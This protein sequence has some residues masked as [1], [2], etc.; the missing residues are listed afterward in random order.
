MGKRTG[1]TLFFVAGLLS[2]TWGAGVFQSAGSGMVVHWRLEETAG[3][4]LDLSG[5][6]PPHNGAWSATGVASLP[7]P[8][9]T[10][11]AMGTA[12]TACLEF[13]GTPGSVSTPGTAATSITGDITIAF[14][15]YAAPT[16]SSDWNRIVGKGNGTQRTFGVW[17]YPNA[18]N[19]IKFQQY[20]QAGTSVIDLDTTNDAAGK[21]VDN[22][23][24][25]IAVRVQTNAVAIFIDGVQN[26]T[27]TRTAAPGSVVTDPVTLAYA[28]YHTYYKGRLDDVRIYNVARSAPGIQA[29]A[30]L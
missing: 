4:A 5:V 2:V 26:V 12:S 19:R 10:P 29:I 18:D 1:G 27:G 17:R 15:M 3:P 23:W 7:G 25:H 9:N 6:T 21:F 16:A 14:W 13:T 20:N 24:T 22:T 8:L 30:T 11:T 28:G